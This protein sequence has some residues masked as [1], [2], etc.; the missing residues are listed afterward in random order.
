METFFL[1][2]GLNFTDRHFKAR[3][4]VSAYKSSL[5]PQHAFWIFPILVFISNIMEQFE[6][7][8]SLGAKKNNSFLL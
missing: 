4:L 2:L 3:S 1:D 8:C 6:Y 7:I 5:H